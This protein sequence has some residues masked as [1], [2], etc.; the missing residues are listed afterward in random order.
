MYKNVQKEFKQSQEK[1]E[2]YRSLKHL[3]CTPERPEE[4]STNVKRSCQNLQIQTLDH[5]KSKFSLKSRL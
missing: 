3:K 4:C 2:K 5:H 1:S